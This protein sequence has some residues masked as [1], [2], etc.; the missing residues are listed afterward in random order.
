M[1]PALDDVPVDPYRSRLYS[2]DELYDTPSYE[3]SYDARAYAWSQRRGGQD[4]ML[5]RTLHDHAIDDALAAWVS[6]RRLVGVMG[7]H[8]VS[9]SEDAY[10]LGRPAGPRG[11]ALG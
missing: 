7:G 2:A 8:A 1:L 10:L 11:S 9:R 3:R 6:D 4:D 5:A